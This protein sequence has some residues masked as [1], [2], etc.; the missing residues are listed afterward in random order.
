[1]IVADQKLL[2]NFISTTSVFFHPL[3]VGFFADPFQGL[4]VKAAS[5]G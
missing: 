1:M 4:A 2:R 3:I 5:I